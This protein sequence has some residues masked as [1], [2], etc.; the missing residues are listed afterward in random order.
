MPRAT[1]DVADFYEDDSKVAI[2]DG[3]DR[4]TQ[5]GNTRV[6][7]SEAVRQIEARCKLMS[8]PRAMTGDRTRYLLESESTLNIYLCQK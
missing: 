7:N 5:M 2:R 3:K 4:I 1:G 6:R 8:Y